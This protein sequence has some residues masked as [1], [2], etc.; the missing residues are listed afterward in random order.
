MDNNLDFMDQ[1]RPAFVSPWLLRPL[2]SQIKLT[3][4]S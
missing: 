4:Q 2:E 1:T 3:E